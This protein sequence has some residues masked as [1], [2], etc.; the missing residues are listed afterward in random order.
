MYK[1]QGN[2]RVRI[3]FR[4]NVLREGGAAYPRGPTLHTGNGASSSANVPRMQT[5][6]PVKRVA[7]VEDAVG[8]AMG[9]VAR[10]VVS[11][12]RMMPQGMVQAGAR[13][14]FSKTWR[15][16]SEASADPRAA[17][18]RRLTAIVQANAATEFGR[19]HQF[20][21]IRGYEDWRS[22]VPIRTWTQV[23]PYV[24]RMVDGEKN[25]LTS[26]EPF[27]YARSSGT[28]GE[29]KNIPVTQAYMDEFRHG[30]RVWMR[31]VAQVMPRAVRGHIL[32]VHS[33]SIE[34]RTKSGIPYGSITAAQGST[35]EDPTGF[36]PVPRHVYTLQHYPSRYYLALRFALERPVSVMSAVNP[37]TL[38]LLCQVLTRES[39][40][41]AKDLETGGLSDA[42][43]ITAEERAYFSRRLHK[44]GA[45]ARRLL[46]SVQKHGVARPV[47]VW[48]SLQGALCWKGGSA[49]FYL[50][51]LRP[52]IPNLPI[53]DFGYAASEGVFTTPLDAGEAQGV[54]LAAGHVMEFIPWAA[55]EAGSRDA[56]P[57]WDL[58]QGERYCL[59]YT[60][61]AAD[62]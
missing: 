13:A 55:Y 32:T 21:A 15:I 25:V 36:D 45:N 8:V 47:D 60:S 43:Q 58:T 28:T 1:R 18:E 51:Q 41:L 9:V 2:V 42:L 5:P 17:Q 50:E 20:E 11:V 7:D 61:D 53:M 30:R 3:G 44:N 48:P 10:G 39:S 24:R 23:L 37:S 59:L 16:F 29:P 26:E 57:M 38:V 33:P 22:R 34:G 62:E 31:Q 52:L 40:S 46:E 14:L 12:V 56:L 6:V 19:E 49:P 4:H 54:A 35:A 27:F